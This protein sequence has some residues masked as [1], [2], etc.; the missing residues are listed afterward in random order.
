[1]ARF[2]LAWEL[3][4]GLGHASRFRP[5]AQGLR[6][7]GHEVDLMLREIVH[8]R[9]VLG[10]L[11]L[12]LL[13]APFWMH[14]TVGGPNPSISLTEIL[15]GNGYLQPDHLDGLAQGW[16]AALDLIRPDVLVADY[17]PTATI[18]AHIKGIPVAAVG[19]GFCLPPDA[20]PLPPFRTW[21]PIE[22]G[23]IAYW[24]QR[25][26][27]TVNTVLARHGAPA[28]P[29]LSAIFRGDKPLLCCWPELDPYLRHEQR[30]D[31]RHDQR[32]TPPAAAGDVDAGLG[33]TFLNEG[34]EAPIWPEGDGPRVFAYV[35]STHGDLL[36]LLQ[37]L[38]QSG[39]R[40]LCYLPEVAAGRPAPLVSPRIRYAGRPVDLAQALP[41]ADLLISH[42][43]EATLAQALLAGVPMLLLPTQAEQFLNAQGVVR[44]GAGL[45]AATHGQPAPYAQLLHALLHTDSYRA[46]AQGMAH[47]YRDFLPSALNQAL[48]AACESLL[49]GH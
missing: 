18:A 15:V 8:A 44:L 11:G 38:E 2:L 12:R 9:S 29:R 40:T 35:R 16:L 3:G 24:E 13:Q 42:A 33:P 20:S 39:C 45:N 22:P 30:H 26:T 19:G 32:H 14:Q 7:Q 48:T 41:Q 46:A 31:Q 5:L 27:Q 17:A 36:A 6:A 47:R 1:M 23:R 25:V 37:A 21:E 10:D 49:N 34:G 4:D 28:V 43:G